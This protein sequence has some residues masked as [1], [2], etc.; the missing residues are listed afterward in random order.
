[1]GNFRFITIIAPALRLTR[2]FTIHDVINVNGAGDAFMAGIIYGLQQ[3]FSLR[4]ACQW[5]A[6]AAAFT[7]SSPDTVAES[8]TSTQLQAFIHNQKSDVM[9]KLA[10]NKNKHR[11]VART[12]K[13]Q[14]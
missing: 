8:L 1:M 7:V 5:G 13:L 12:S 10:Y 6:A 11:V 2:W 9:P 3:Q 4:N 14:E